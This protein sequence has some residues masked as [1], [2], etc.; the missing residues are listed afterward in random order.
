MLN[1]GLINYFGSRQITK[2]TI[3]TS[4]SPPQTPSLRYHSE[5][6]KGQT[7]S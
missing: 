4:K 7:R 2:K 6:L 1:L 3:D 5:T